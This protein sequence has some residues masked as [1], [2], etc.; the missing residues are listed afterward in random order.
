M[1]LLEELAPGQRVQTGDRLVEEEQLGPLG[2]GQGEGE[3]GPLA[4]G[5]RAGPLAGVEAELLD[6][7]SAGQV[8]SQ[9]G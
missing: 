1:R 7:A 4:A 3:L 9:A 6:P 2:D 8:P 5:Q